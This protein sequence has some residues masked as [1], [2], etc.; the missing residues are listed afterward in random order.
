M[1]SPA[2][3]ERVEMGSLDGVYRLLTVVLTQA[4]TKSA[5]W[6]QCL[7]TLWQHDGLV[8]W[9]VLSATSSDIDKS[10]TGMAF[11]CS[12]LDMAAK[13][14]RTFAG[15]VVAMATVDA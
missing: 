14:V 8:V 15:R 12:E 2:V 1:A 13:H 9:T 11:K 5:G 10:A 3:V 7:T 6:S 4:V